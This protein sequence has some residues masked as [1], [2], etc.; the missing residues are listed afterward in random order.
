MQSHFLAK[1]LALGACALT[2]LAALLAPSAGSASSHAGAA[3]V[4]PNCN[5]ATNIEAILDDSTSMLGNDPIRARAQ[6]IEILAKLPDNAAKQMAGLEFGSTANALFPLVTVGTGLGTIQAGLNLIQA[7]NGGTNYNAAFNLARTQNPN[8]NARIF[9][10]DGENTFTPYTNGH[11]TPNIKTYVVGLGSFDPTLLNKI[12][13]DTGGQLF[14]VATASDVLKVAMVLNSRL[15]C[16]TD[17]V[18]FTDL[19]RQVNHLSAMAVAAKKASGRKHAFRPDGSTASIV[20]SHGTAGS[21]IRGLGF[22]QGKRRI[23]ASVSRGANYQLYNLSGLK[24]GK[25]RFQVVA[26]KLAGPTTATTQIQP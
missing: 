14:S 22:L 19:F 10:S 20:I 18:T 15:N 9:L 25:V 1:R 8:A 24:K 2:G 4:I 6:I 26:K 3:A 13:A 5:S 21:V 16:L 23:R 7:D 17:P 11:L 12:V